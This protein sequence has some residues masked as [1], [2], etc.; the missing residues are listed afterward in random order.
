MVY[1]LPVIGIRPQWHPARRRLLLVASALGGTACSS[2]FGAP[3]AATAQGEAVLDLWRI[4]FWAAVAVGTLVVVLIGWALVRYRVREGRDPATFFEHVRLE[5]F[6]TAVP[7]VI[8]AVL[9]AATMLTQR[10]VNRLAPEPD[11]R[12]EV[13]GFQWGW[14]FRYLT[15]GITVVGTSLDPPTMVLPVDAAARLTLHSPDVIHAFWVPGFLIK[16]DVIPNHVNRLDVTPTRTGTFGGVCAEFCGLDHSDM[17]FTVEVV[18]PEQFQ[19][20][21]A[22]QQQEEQEQGPTP[23]GTRGGGND[24]GGQALPV[25][26]ARPEGVTVG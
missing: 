25:P 5:L 10:E 1:R 15:E 3:D 22:Q 26:A 14:R 11:L 8:V 2:R 6:Y 20:F 12:I 23:P 18:E 17:T 4:L 9:F 19:A 16:R 7:L 13:T 24:P 21:V